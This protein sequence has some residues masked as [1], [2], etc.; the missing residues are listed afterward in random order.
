MTVTYLIGN[1]FDIGLGLK[2]RYFDFL[3]K[4]VARPNVSSGPVRW[5]IDQIKNSPCETWAD[6]EK[7]FGELE[8]SKSGFDLGE[9]IGQSLADFQNE[10]SQC[11][12]AESERLMIPEDDSNVVSGLFLEGIVK[13][14]LLQYSEEKALAEFHELTAPNML[15]INIINFNYTDSVAKLLGPFLNHSGY[16][17]VRV[18]NVAVD[19]MVNRICYVHGSLSGRTPIF[20][21]DEVSQIADDESRRYCS[22]HGVLVK[23]ATDRLLDYGFEDRARQMIQKSDRVVCFGLSYGKTDLRWWNCIYD[24]L[25]KNKR[26]RL[27]LMPYF[28]SNRVCASAT[29]QLYITQEVR[30]RFLVSL[31]EVNA[32]SSLDDLPGYSDISPRMVVTKHYPHYDF[33]KNKHHSDPFNLAWFGKKYVKDWGK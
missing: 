21:V 14:L 20:G 11:L 23:S 6:A 9:T 18:G 3:S 27:M 10:L 33:D 12:V 7:A 8:F 5:L 31:R 30:E 4:Y 17:K 25:G 26:S 24:A 32:T 1:G 13:S 2:T 29:D 16:A 15:R 28:D 19:A 22:C